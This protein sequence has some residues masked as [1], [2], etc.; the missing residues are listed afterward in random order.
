MQREKF[1]FS[2]FLIRQEDDFEEYLVLQMMHLKTISAI[3]ILLRSIFMKVQFSACS[4]KD[5]LIRLNE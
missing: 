1:F 5:F 2:A 3:N 4:I